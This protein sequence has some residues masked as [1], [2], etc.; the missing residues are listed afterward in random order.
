MR[1]S[2]FN[3]QVE[4]TCMN[5]SFHQDGRF[6]PIKLAHPRHFL[7]NCFCQTREL[8]AIYVFIRG[9]VWYLLLLFY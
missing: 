5:I 9:V 3:S 8:V 6:E 7:L 4:N 1:W 2:V